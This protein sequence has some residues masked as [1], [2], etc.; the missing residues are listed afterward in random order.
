MTTILT[1]GVGDVGRQY[2][3]S[4]E[5]TNYCKVKC[6]LD[7]GYKKFSNAKLSLGVNVVPPEFVSQY[8]NYSTVLIAT[9]SPDLADKF[10][11]CISSTPPEKIIETAI[12]LLEI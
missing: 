12:Q 2:L 3:Q 1:G 6:V 5:K 9:A 8:Q 11:E 10:G 7:N 4:I